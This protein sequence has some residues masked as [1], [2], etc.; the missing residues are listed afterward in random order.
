MPPV[1][2]DAAV[3]ARG[4][5]TGAD[6]VRGRL[7]AGSIRL[8]VRHR[9]P[10][11]RLCYERALKRRPGLAGVVEIRL[12]VGA[13][14]R[15]TTAT[16]HRNTTGHDGLGKCIAYTMKRWRFPR[17]VDGVETEVI[18]PFGFSGGSNHE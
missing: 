16:V 9:L 2:K 1:T 5:V 11:I 14:G 6:E 13:D 7:N 18:Y 15:A 12:L 3:D 8:V 10:Q 4:A 17:P